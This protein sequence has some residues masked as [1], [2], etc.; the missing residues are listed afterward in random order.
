MKVCRDSC[1][2]SS[3]LRPCESVIKATEPL[4]S[5]SFDLKTGR[6][7]H[8]YLSLSNERAAFK[9]RFP[10]RFCL[11]GNASNMTGAGAVED[12]ARQS[13]GRYFS[14][15]A[16][17][18][19]SASL[20]MMDRGEADGRPV[21]PLPFGSLWASHIQDKA[22]AHHFRVKNVKVP[23]LWVNVSRNSL[24]DASCRWDL[25]QMRSNW[26]FSH[27]STPL[28]PALLHVLFSPFFSIVPH[29]NDLGPWNKQLWGPQAQPSSTSLGP[30][31]PR[32]SS[33]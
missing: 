19:S 17:E 5:L 22:S 4:L 27:L 14:P 24:S 1:T 12:E 6:E 8:K 16:P 13:W 30:P 3:W 26:T 11:R 15:L 7:V 20:T 9:S 25:I 23:H 32:R 21:A 31:A 28:C 10:M 2:M 29:F 33:I 18:K